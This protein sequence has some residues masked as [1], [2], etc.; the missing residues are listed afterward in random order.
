MSERGEKMKFKKKDE[1]FVPTNSF[2]HA[3]LVAQ[4]ITRPVCFGKKSK[5]II[6][7]D[8]ESKRTYIRYYEEKKAGHKPSQS[9]IKA[10]SNP[11]RLHPAKGS[12]QDG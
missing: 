1:L 6:D 2:I 3:A 5:I 7:F 8:P 10:D 12:S 9:D 11:S 4:L